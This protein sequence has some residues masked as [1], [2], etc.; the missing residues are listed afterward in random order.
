MT[1]RVPFSLFG[2]AR[3]PNPLVQEKMSELLIMLVTQPNVK[4]SGVVGLLQCCNELN[5]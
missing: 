4:H 5:G 3:Y 1:H 2:V